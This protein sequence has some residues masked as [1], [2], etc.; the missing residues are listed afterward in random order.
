MK[1]EISGL[2]VHVANL[3]ELDALVRR[4]GR[5]AITALGAQTGVTPAVSETSDAEPA[6][7]P[8]GGVINPR[9]RFVPEKVKIPS[10]S[11]KEAMWKL[12]DAIESVMHK[13]AIRL[14]ASKGADGLHVSDLRKALGVPENYKTAGFTASI[15]RRAPAYGLT[16]DEV[17]IVEFLGAVAGQRI[18]RY[19][20]TPEMIEVLS[21]HGLATP[22][23]PVLLRSAEDG[24]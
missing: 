12:F 14:L 1:V 16:G 13:N 23:K 15:T 20:L 22:G 19:R 7:G 11:K 24:G 21:E 4:Y 17:L 5:S 3:D 9:V 6:R 8:R 2:T 10:A 18:Y